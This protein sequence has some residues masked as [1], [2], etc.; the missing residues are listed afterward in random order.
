LAASTPF[1]DPSRIIDD[2]FS[3]E[4]HSFPSRTPFS[5]LRHNGI[6]LESEESRGL[7]ANESKTGV[8]AAL[9]PF[10]PSLAESDGRSFLV[11]DSIAGVSTISGVCNAATDRV[12]WEDDAVADVAV[13]WGRL[14][15]GFVA[16]TAVTLSVE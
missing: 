15:Q 9:P 6:V 10:G 11:G 2:A 14:A 12:D 7:L 13:G 16:G 3:I 8:D 1:V 5:F 4:I